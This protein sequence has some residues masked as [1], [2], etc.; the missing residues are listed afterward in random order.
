MGI[1]GYVKRHRAAFRVIGL[2]PNNQY[3][4]EFFIQFRR[5]G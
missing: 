2:G 1:A 4:S 3:L 5:R